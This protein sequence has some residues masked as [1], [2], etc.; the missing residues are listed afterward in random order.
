LYG[1][2]ENELESLHAALSR[3]QDFRYLWFGTK[4]IAREIIVHRFIAVTPECGVVLRGIKTLMAPVGTVAQTSAQPPDPVCTRS[5]GMEGP[6][7]RCSLFMK[8]FHSGPFWADEAPRVEISEMRVVLDEFIDRPFFVVGDVAYTSPAGSNVVR[9]DCSNYDCSNKLAGPSRS[10]VFARR[11]FVGPWNSTPTAALGVKHVMR[12]LRTPGQISD[13]RLSDAD[14]AFR[15][16]IMAL[17][18]RIADDTAAAGRP[19]PMALV[20]TLT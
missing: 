5:D 7:A 1:G 11:G 9:Y 14:R 17:E 8:D 10:F 13:D 18:N 15:R 3:L 12:H 2:V 19:L 20:S 4:V 16:R 6:V